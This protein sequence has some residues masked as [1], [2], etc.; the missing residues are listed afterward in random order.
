MFFNEKF[1]KETETYNMLIFLFRENM[2]I[3]FRNQI[4]EI[5]EEIMKNWYLNYVCPL[6]IFP[7]Y[8]FKNIEYLEKFQNMKYEKHNYRFVKKHGDPVF[9]RKNC[10]NSFFVS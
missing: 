8:D 5:N 9:F 2:P 6:F 3:D 10:T 7:E 1:F 4:I